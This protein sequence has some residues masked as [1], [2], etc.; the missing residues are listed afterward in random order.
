M[1]IQITYSSPGMPS[2]Y[3][4]LTPTDSKFVA[5]NVGRMLEA[6]R[7][8]MNTCLLANGRQVHIANANEIAKVGG[9]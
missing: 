5:E 6:E 9:A 8:V 3:G 2:P 7:T 4:N 1:L